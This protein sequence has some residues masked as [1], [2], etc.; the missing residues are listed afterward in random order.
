[1]VEINRSQLII[2]DRLLCKLH[3]NGESKS[4]ELFIHNSVRLYPVTLIRLV[5]ASLLRDHSSSDAFLQQWSVCVFFLCVRQVFPPDREAANL[6]HSDIGISIIAALP[7]LPI[8]FPLWGGF[9]SVG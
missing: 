3:T 9:A 4:D 1:M 8:K 5:E 7:L 6:I 2:A